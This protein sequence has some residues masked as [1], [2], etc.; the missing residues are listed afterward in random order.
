[1]ASADCDDRSD[2]P[3]TLLA[4][5]QPPAT[6]EIESVDLDSGAADGHPPPHHL[7]YLVHFGAYTP[8]DI[9]NLCITYCFMLDDD[10]GDGDDACHPP[11]ITITGM[12]RE[13]A[14]LKAQ[15]T[16][17]DPRPCVYSRNWLS[18]SGQFHWGM[19][20]QHHVK[21]SRGRR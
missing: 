9:I 2:E 13:M 8:A 1:M 18:P 17:R 19:R 14:T 12:N 11:S 16:S 3:E 6:W 15:H 5:P 10:D 4:C 20:T 7:R 21:T